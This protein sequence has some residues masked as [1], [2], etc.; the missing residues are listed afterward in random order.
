MSA[1]AEGMGRAEASA[2]AEWLAYMR[3]AV[4]QTCLTMSRFT[5]D[6]VFDRVDADPHAPTTHEL[7]A[8][9]PVVLGAAAA[10]WCQKA[11]VAPVPSRRESLHSSPR[12]VWESL[13][14]QANAA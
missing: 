4:R 7:R 9:G 5:S 13:L 12:S 14:V 8:F 6:D 10:G 1:K 2:N 3:E 11:N